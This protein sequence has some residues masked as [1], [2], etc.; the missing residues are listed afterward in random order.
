MHLQS[1]GRRAGFCQ[2]W[3]GEEGAFGGDGGPAIL[4]EQAARTYFGVRLAFHPERWRRIRVPEEVQQRETH[5]GV[6]QRETHF[7][8]GS[9]ADSSTF[10]EFAVNRKFFCNILRILHVQMNSDSV[11]S[12]VHVDVLSINSDLC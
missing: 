6:Q 12:Y 3:P 7:L 2:R 11:V 8:N 10:E 5:P 1:V 4:R 9:S